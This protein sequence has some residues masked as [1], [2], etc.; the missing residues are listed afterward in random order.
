MVLEN[1]SVPF[2]T[3]KPGFFGYLSPRYFVEKELWRDNSI[4]LY[5]FK[6]IA[7][8]NIT[9]SLQPEKSFTVFNNGDHSFEV[10]DFKNNLISGVDQQAV[11]EYIGNYRKV[12]CESYVADFSQKRLD[13]LLQTRP[14]AI[15][16]VKNRKGEINTL[17][18]FPRPNFLQFLDGNGEVLPNDPDAMYGV[19]KGDMQ[20]V[21]CQYFV[22]DPLIKQISFFQKMTPV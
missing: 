4:F 8:V 2:V 5:S 16:S 12:R 1:S 9:Y 17:K 11:K 10:K 7:S 19:L 14:I 21:V 20:V 18:L 3:F 6:D 13:S 22:F 15:I